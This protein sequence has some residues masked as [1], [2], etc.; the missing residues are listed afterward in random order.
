MY[1]ALGGDESYDRSE[2]WPHYSFYIIFPFILQLKR[3][4]QERPGPVEPLV[5]Q[6]GTLA[7]RRNSIDPTPKGRID[8]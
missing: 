2:E 6:V 4:I 5:F 7:L 3:D 1:A 8:I